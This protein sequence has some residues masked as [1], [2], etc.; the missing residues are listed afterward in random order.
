MECKIIQLQKKLTK[1]PFVRFHQ[2]AECTSMRQPRSHHPDSPLSTEM[3]KKKKENLNDQGS[4][5]LNVQMCR[6]MNCT[7]CI[8]IKNG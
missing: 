5:H 6:S 4:N 2:T 8:R 7:A 1:R 3:L